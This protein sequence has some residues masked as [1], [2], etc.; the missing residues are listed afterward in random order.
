MRSAENGNVSA[1]LAL[2]NPGKLSHA[3]W[4]TTAN[5][6]MRLYVA[7][8]VPDESICLLVTYIAKVYAPCWF[9]VKLRPSCV[10]GTRHLFQL[11]KSCSLL[12]EKL[13]K[14]IYPVIQRNGFFA[15]PGHILLSMLT[16]EDQKYRELSIRRILK[17]RSKG[18]Q[19][20]REFNIPVIRVDEVLL[21]HH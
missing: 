17:A 7:N 8:E 21:N 10:D 1:S 12:P 4:L 6:I 16:D 14:I 18:R 19:T 3:R 5:R 15:H 9:R 13:K 2:R 20:I 11:I